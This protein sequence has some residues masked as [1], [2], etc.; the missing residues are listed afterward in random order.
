MI[1]FRHILPVLY[2]SIRQALTTSQNLTEAGCQ[3]INWKAMLLPLP[4]SLNI[5]QR[6]TFVTTKKNICYNKEIHT[7][8]GSDN[9]DGQKG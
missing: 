9:V 4:P 5:K 6:K 8:F 1:S 2:L 3:Y 7:N